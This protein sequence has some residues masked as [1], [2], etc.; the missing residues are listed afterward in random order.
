MRAANGYGLVGPMCLGS[1]KRA[2][3]RAILADFYRGIDPIEAR[4]PK[5]VMPTYREYLDGDYAAWAK[6]SQKAYGQNLKR[7]ATG[8]Q[9]RT[10]AGIAASSAKR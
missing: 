3:A 10:A 9:L 6:S 1:V 8:V 5:A 2:K 4:K 7:L